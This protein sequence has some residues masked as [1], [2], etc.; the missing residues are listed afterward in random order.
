MKLPTPTNSQGDVKVANQNRDSKSLDLD[1]VKILA[2]PTSITS[3]ANPG[4]TSIDVTS[5]AGFAD[6]VVVGLTSSLGYFY[7]GEQVGAVAGNT[8]N[9]DTPID[10]TFAVDT[11][12]NAFAATRNLAVD[13]STTTQIFQVGPF[14]TPGLQIEI[15]RI[16]GYIQDATAMDDALFGGIAALTYGIVLRKNN[17]EFDNVWN[18]KTNGRFAQI[19]GGD[20]NYTEKAPAGSYGARA[21]NTYT[22]E[23]KHGTAIRLS[24]GDTL[25]ILVQDDLTGLEFLHFMA[26]G[27]YVIQ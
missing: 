1:F 17:A 8:I 21:R 18:I 20:F 12:T 15:T 14:S 11:T 19:T 6:K 25:E 26:Q 2:P 10:R 4:D 27:H 9:L 16:H 3:Q 7:F 23:D 22:G 13:G 5:T 24:P